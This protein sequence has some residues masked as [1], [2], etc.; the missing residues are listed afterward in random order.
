M[1]QGLLLPALILTVSG[2]VAML[3]LPDLGGLLLGGIAYG[4]GLGGFQTAIFLS[5]LRNAADRDAIS[6]VWNICID[7]GGVMGTL[8]IGALA[9]GYGARAALWAAPAA[10][11]MASPAL[12]AL[13]RKVAAP[14]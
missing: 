10:I 11:A 8:L 12:L 14:P 4:I 2:L 9:A 7:L 6:A 3:I 13:R 5:M 1:P